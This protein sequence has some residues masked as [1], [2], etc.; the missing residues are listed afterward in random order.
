MRADYF[1]QT[2]RPWPRWKVILAV[3][4][5]VIAYGYV[6]HQDYVDA[7][8]DECWSHGQQR[9]DEATDTCYKEPRNAPSSQ[10]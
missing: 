6:G 2:P 5:F 7:R 1:D 9:Y 10:N 4:F 8:V 3:L